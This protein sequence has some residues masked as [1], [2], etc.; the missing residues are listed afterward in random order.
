MSDFI[1]RRELPRI[2]VSWPVTVHTSEGEWTGETRNLS[3]SGA[4]IQCN[5]QLNVNE[6]YWL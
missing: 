6:M 4:S 3:P 2:I 1:E 5:E